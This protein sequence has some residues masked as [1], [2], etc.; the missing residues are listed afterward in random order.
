MTRWVEIPV[1][2]QKADKDEDATFGN[3]AKFDND[4]NPVDSG[5]SKDDV[6]TKEE[7]EEGVTTDVIEASGITIDGKQCATKDLVGQE[8]NFATT[9]GFMNAIAACVRAFGGTVVNNP[10]EQSQGGN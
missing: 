2:S 9:Q 5:I 3:L 4:G 7:L 10:S 6:V 1:L 8:F